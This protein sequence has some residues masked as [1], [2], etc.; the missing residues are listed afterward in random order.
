MHIDKNKDI[1]GFE[2]GDSIQLSDDI[3]EQMYQCGAD[4][5]S[6][7]HS[8]HIAES[9]KTLGPDAL[10]FGDV[11]GFGVLTQGNPDD[12]DNVVK[13]AINN[14]VN[15]V[16]PGCDIWPTVPRKNMG[17]LMTA[18]LKYGKRG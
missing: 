10:I 6:V 15:A 13:A 8:N 11:D 16:W 12:V 5:I 4:A 1:R 17:A 7:D 2:F 14:G 9:R 3:I 18:S